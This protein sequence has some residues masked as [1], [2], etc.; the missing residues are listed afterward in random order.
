MLGIIRQ[1]QLSSFDGSRVPSLILA[2][3]YITSEDLW[4]RSTLVVAGSRRIRKF[5]GGRG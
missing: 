3:R 4:S 5:L 1:K 2:H